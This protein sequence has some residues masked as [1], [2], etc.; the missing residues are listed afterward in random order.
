MSHP[1]LEILNLHS[2]RCCSRAV[3][4]MVS[5][6]PLGTDYEGG[7]PAGVRRSQGRAADSAQMRCT[8]VR[9]P[10]PHSRPLKELLHAG[11]C[12]LGLDAAPLSGED[13]PEPACGELGLG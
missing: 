4:S 6:G 13:E 12:M 5:Y 3:S 7:Q 10:L 2:G 1:K 11:Q 9:R 8:V